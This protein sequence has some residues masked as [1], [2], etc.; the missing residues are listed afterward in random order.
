M[1]YE[2]AEAMVRGRLSEHRLRHT[3]NVKEMALRLARRYGVTVAALKRANNLRSD[4]IHTGQ[5]LVIPQ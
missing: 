1:T 3:L 5:R 4:N 2:Q